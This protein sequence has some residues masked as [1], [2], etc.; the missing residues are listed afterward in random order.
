MVKVNERDA[1]ALVKNIP[2]LAELALT[3]T[4]QENIQWYPIRIG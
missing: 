2:F 4:H 1:G 3:V